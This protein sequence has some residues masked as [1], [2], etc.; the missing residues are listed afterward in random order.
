VSAFREG[1]FFHMPEEEYFSI[2]ALSASGIKLLRMSPLDYWARTS[3]LNPDYQE[4]EEVSVAKRIGKAYD[5]RITE[6]KAAFESCYAPSITSDEIPN[7]LCAV[8]EI[9]SR[10]REL[11]EAGR[12]V[13]I[14]HKRKEDFV[15]ELLTHDPQA[16][17]WDLVKHQYEAM[18]AGKELISRVLIESIEIAA[19]MIEKHPKLSLAFS[20]GAPQVSIFWTCPVIGINCKARLDYLKPRAIV[21]LK[22]F[23]NKWQRPVD[24][25]IARELSANSYQRQAAWYYE[26]TDQIARLISEGL[27]DEADPK[28][29]ELSRGLAEGYPK[30]FMF[31]FQQKG[32][33]PLARGKIFRRELNNCAIAAA[34]NEAAKQT[35]RECLE[36]FGSDPWVDDS[37][38]TNLTD[39]ELPVFSLE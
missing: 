33:A 37:E 10:L 34:H 29:H 18:H 39:E 8:D 13:K 6:G 31:V 32:E 9:K 15:A 28:Y 22:T 25:A 1:I 5:K 36:K 4:P 24:I 30:T 21:D 14:T 20:G 19:A 38:I 12:D 16:K 35:Y 3:W 23:A 2:P 7:V 17:V 26:A 27:S 11:K